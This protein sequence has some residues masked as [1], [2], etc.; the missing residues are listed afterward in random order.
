[1]RTN[2]EILGK[3]VKYMVIAMGLMVL[4]PFLLHFGFQATF[5]ALLENT[6]LSRIYTAF[7]RPQSRARCSNG[8]FGSLKITRL[9]DGK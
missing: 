2:K 3:G 7:L 8:A 9:L 6:L 1:M 4:G 5:V